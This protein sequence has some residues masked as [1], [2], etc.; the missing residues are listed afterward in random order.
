MRPVQLRL[1]LQA[2]CSV[3]KYRQTVINLNTQAG[4]L[5][6]PPQPLSCSEAFSL[7]HC[8]AS[9]AHDT[10]LL[11]QIHELSEKHQLQELFGECPNAPVCP[12]IILLNVYVWMRFST[13]K[14]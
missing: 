12:L 14:K 7:L 2:L 4:H 5:T 3:L 10:V 1:F 6:I 8:W 11:T 13:Q 9:L